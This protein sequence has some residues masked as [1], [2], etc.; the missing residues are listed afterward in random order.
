MSYHASAHPLDAD[1][2]DYLED[3]CDPL[4]VSLIESHLAGC[5]LCRI[6]R[7]RLSDAFPVDL[8]ELR[9]SAVPRFDTIQSE[10]ASGS[11]AR[12]GELWLT[13]SE[14][15]SIVLVRSIRS[16]GQGVVVIPVTLD[17]EVGDSGSL[18]LSAEVSPLGV[19]LA[20]YVDLMVSLPSSAL[21]NRILPAKGVDLLS[22]ADG[23]PGVSRGSALEGLADPRH[24]VRQVLLDRLV[25]LDPY[26][27]DEGGDNGHSY[28]ASRIVELRD[29]L[30]FRRGSE[31]VVEENIS[32][33]FLAIAPDGWTGVAR[34]K[35]FAVQIIVIDT[36]A[37]LSDET[38][39]VWAQMLL[40]RLGGS[41]LAVCTSSIDTVEL[42][43]APTLFRAFQ[44]PNGDRAS[45]PSLT[46]LSLVDTIAKFLEQKNVSLSALGP[47]SRDQ[48]RLD[49]AQVL[50]ASVVEAV[51]ANVKRATRFRMDKKAGYL[52]LERLTSDLII[53]LR[54]ALDADF[55]PESV[56]RLAAEDR[57]G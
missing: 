19:P 41:A 51:A 27:P 11:D 9:P 28:F 52:E 42:Y 20:V 15:A 46:G 37:G 32:L 26:E 3:A 24:E 53:A 45:S 44:L 7:Q 34:I 33:P 31:C 17:V 18:I 40:A 35:E 48:E 23:M 50:A 36:P 43:D 6:K 10:E 55:D 56:A 2:L 29:E 38:D 16:N 39:V 49:V 47:L 12:P 14:E 8:A 54:P 22:L 57:E 13:V 1:L 25:A 4:V 30:T 5:V 21:S